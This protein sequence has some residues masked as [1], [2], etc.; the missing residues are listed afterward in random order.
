MKFVFLAFIAVLSRTVFAE[1]AEIRW[2]LLGPAFS[3]HANMDGARIV[4]QASKN[5]LKCADS[6]FNTVLAARN[7]TCS[8]SITPEQR[9]WIQ[10]NPAIGI[11]W[12]QVTK[13]HRNRLFAMTVRDSYGE[14]GALAG[15]GR[16]WPLTQISSFRFEGGLSAGLWY[17]TFLSETIANQY[18]STCD[19]NKVLECTFRGEAL[20]VSVFER[21]LVPFIFP[22]LT[23]TEQRSGIGLSLVLVPKLKIGKVSVVPTPTLMVQLSYKADL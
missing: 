17:R 10:S 7:L 21:R 19:Y 15:A 6:I 23:L 20:R 9:E 4:K 14:M 8:D 5:P 11:E 12:S 1:A 16:S 13:H 22:E 3:H 18:L 2:R